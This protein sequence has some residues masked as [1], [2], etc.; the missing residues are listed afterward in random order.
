MLLDGVVA[1]LH[2]LFRGV[3]LDAC[4]SG[5]PFL[6]GS[7]H[8]VGRRL[9]NGDDFLMGLVGAFTGL[10]KSGPAVF[11]AEV[12]IGSVLEKGGYDLEFGGFMCWC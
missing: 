8:V 6:F 12:G 9:Q 1:C 5:G 2:E 3:G 4:V 11:V 7:H 10:F